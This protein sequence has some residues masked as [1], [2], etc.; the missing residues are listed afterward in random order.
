[1]RQRDQAV[2]R[3]LGQFAKRIGDDDKQRQKIDEREKSEEGINRDPPGDVT[4]ARS[5]RRADRSH[6]SKVAPT[7][8]GPATRAPSRPERVGHQHD[9]ERQQHHDR[10]GRA[11]SNSTPLEHEIVDVDRRKGRRDAGSAS[12]E[13]DDKVEGLDREL[14]ENDGDRD[15][16]RCDRRQDHFAIDARGAGPS[17]WAALT[18]SDRPNAGRRET[19][20]SRIPKPARSRWR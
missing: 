16:D 20:P 9:R 14:Q 11:D 7:M 6:A 10:G 12:G 17:I 19:G 2:A 13:C 18:R 4:Q 15:K 5:L 8:G 1:M 3:D